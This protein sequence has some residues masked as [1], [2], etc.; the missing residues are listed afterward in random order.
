[1]GDGGGGGRGGTFIVAFYC[2]ILLLFMAV[3]FVLLV[4]VASPR[5]FPWCCSVCFD[6]WLL[7]FVCRNGNVM[8]PAVL[9]STVSW[10]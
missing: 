5:L 2:I 4:V 1:M 9:F 10:C 7:L 6:E 8:D 3:L